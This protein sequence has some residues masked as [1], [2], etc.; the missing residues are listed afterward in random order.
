MHT[1][2]EACSVDRMVVYPGDTCLDGRCFKSSPYLIVTRSDALQVD[3]HD[4]RVPVG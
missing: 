1:L 3:L 4:F 2:V